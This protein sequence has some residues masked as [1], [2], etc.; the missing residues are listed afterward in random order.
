MKM[1]LCIEKNCNTYKNI[2]IFRLKMIILIDI[3]KTKT[4]ND[5]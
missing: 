3:I 4:K 1:N 2:S 5:R